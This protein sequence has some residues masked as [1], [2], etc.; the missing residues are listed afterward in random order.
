MG[1]EIGDAFAKALEKLV[2]D[3]RVF[4][5]E[6]ETRGYCSEPDHGQKLHIDDLESGSAGENIARRIYKGGVDFAVPD[7][8][9]LGCFAA[10]A[11]DLTFTEQAVL[12]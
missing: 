11:L 7:I 1:L 12:L 10:E 9:P 3:V 4:L 2:H 5:D 8:F 6:I